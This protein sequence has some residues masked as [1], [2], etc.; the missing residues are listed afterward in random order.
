M[1][2]VSG[3]IVAGALGLTAPALAGERGKS[4]SFVDENDVFFSG[5]DR[6]Y[7]QGLKFAFTWS[8]G[9]TPGFVRDLAEK[10]F[11]AEAGDDVAFTASLGQS[12]FTPEDISVSAP[13]PGQ[14]P[15]AGWLYAG[16]SVTAL[17]AAE[18][19]VAPATIDS[20]GFEAGV[21]GPSSLAEPV[22]RE[23][24]KLIDGQDPKGWDNQLK[25]EPGLHLFYD[26]HWGYAALGGRKSD[27]P[28]GLGLEIWPSVGLFLGNV[29]T[30]GR[31]GLGARLGQGLPNDPWG[32]PRTRPSLSGGDALIGGEGFSWYVF[33]KGVGRA[34]AHN[35][36]L[37]GNT[38]RDHSPGVQRAPLVGEIQLGIA[39]Q[40]GRVRT[41]YTLI[42][43][44]EE[45]DG[46]DD[47]QRF[48]ALSVTVGF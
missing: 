20:F 30:E 29:L 19:G 13:L 38:F 16:L 22:Q 40:F 23:F 21:I 37:D 6:N 32:P 28:L 7:T 45:F 1:R 25:D 11:D 10:W 44:T 3:L 42:N 2:I 41:A 39:A 36:V 34:V 48:G 4:L 27:T 43:R 17:D 26:R 18:T 47:A 33:A 8:A 24:H 31:V 12:I 46:Q 14:H 9:G 35:V 5:T 15:Y